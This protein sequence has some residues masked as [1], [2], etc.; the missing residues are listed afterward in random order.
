MC[1]RRGSE[2]SVRLEAA[3]P[4]GSYSVHVIDDED[5]HGPFRPFEAESELLLKSRE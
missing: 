3:E 1:P 5:L 2:R 4:G